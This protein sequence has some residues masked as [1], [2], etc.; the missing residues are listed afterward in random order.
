MLREDAQQLTGPPDCR[1]ESR[2]GVPCQL[3]HFFQF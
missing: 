3:G 2:I 1:D